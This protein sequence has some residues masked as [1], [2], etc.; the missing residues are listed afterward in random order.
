MRTTASR[1]LLAG[2]VSALLVATVAVAPA[3]AED[4]PPSWTTVPGTAVDVDGLQIA[5]ETAAVPMNPWGLHPS[6]VDPVPYLRPVGVNAS[7]RTRWIGFGMDIAQQGIV[8]PLWEA[9]S[10]GLAGDESAELTDVFSVELAPGAPLQ[11]SLLIEEG[12]PSWSGRT[13]QIFELSG[14]PESGPSL[15]LLTT[16]TDPG[17]FVPVHLDIATEQGIPEV[18]R[19]LEVTSTGAS[20]DLFPGVAA[21]VAGDGLVAGEQLEL[22]LAPGMDG[23]FLLLLGGTLPAGAVQVGTAT[24]AS[25]GT[26]RA[27]ITIPAGTALGRYQ[28]AAGVPGERYWPAGSR[29]DFTITEPDATSDEET[30]SD[31][32]PF[33]I[34]LTSTAVTFTFPVGA[35]A[36]TTTAA[37]TATGPDPSGFT[38]ASNPPLYYH[39]STTSEI[40]GVVEVCIVYDETALPGDPPRLYHHTPAGSGGYTWQDITTSRIPGRVC[41]ETDSFS[42][43]VLGIPLHDGSTHAPARA[44]LSSDNGHDTGLRDGDYTVSVDLWWGENASSVRLL[45]DGVA[46]AEQ[47][48]VRGTPRAQH[49]EFPIT[50]LSNGNR[51]YTAE[52]SNSTGTT[53]THPLTVRV[54]DA[55][56]ARPALSATTPRNG[57][58]TL[59][60]DLW[61]GTNATSA[62]FTENGVPIGAPMPLVANTPE[63][64]S[65][66]VTL[67]RPPGQRS[68]AVAFSN[69]AGST[70]SALRTVRVR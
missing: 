33:T 49:A 39:L 46:I 50:G 21:T 67:T 38:L 24:V 69:A 29:R 68:Y 52:L 53:T 7:D 34:P 18:G 56:P 4:P 61:W 62:Q 3:A 11:S 42:A 60:A 54:T 27:D 37:V 14:P 64:Q 17:R 70:W 41:G 31:G 26:L 58:F 23:F 6:G 28:L 43:F 22:W 30:P 25:D 36:G 47:Q 45:E 66:S 12:V 16:T 32:T 20:A 2:L 10:W 35:G 48:L 57:T 19:A 65:V 55:N 40:D 51:V 15:S 63:A 13:F 5:F 59:T 1:S 44:V 8:E 9:E